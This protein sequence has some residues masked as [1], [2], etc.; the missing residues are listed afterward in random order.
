MN[1]FQI[2]TKRLKV[3]HKRTGEDPY[4]PTM[5]PQESYSMPTMQNLPTNMDLSNSQYNGFMPNHV[6]EQQYLPIRQ[7]IP[8]QLVPTNQMMG[9]QFGFRHQS[10]VVSY[11]TNGRSRVSTSAISPHPFV[12]MG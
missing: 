6:Q 7:I 3:Q 2:G 1:G 5:P 11:P 4:S 8:N 12:Q 10:Q 9:H